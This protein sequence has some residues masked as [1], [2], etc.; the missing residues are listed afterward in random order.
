MKS[1]SIFAKTLPTSYFIYPPPSVSIKPLLLVPESEVRSLLEEI[2]IDLDLQLSFPAPVHERGF[3]LNFPDDGQPRPRF[4]GTSSSQAEFKA[5]EQ[6]VPTEESL[7]KGV[8]SVA[9]ATDDRSYEAFKTKMHAGVVAIQKKTK[10][11]KDKKKLQRVHQK[12]GNSN[13]P[14]WSSFTDIK[15]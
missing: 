15:P 8:S 6:Q 5:M 12:E 4:L 11:A 7:V 1:T 3:L 2:N 14:F 13:I 9:L 10:A